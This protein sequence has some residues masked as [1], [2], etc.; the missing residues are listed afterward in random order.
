M[1]NEVHKEDITLLFYTRE[2]IVVGGAPI[3]AAGKGLS[4]EPKKFTLNPIG[5]S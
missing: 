2:S 4:K 5:F 3:L 1:M